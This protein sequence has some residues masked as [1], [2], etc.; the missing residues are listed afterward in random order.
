MVNGT[1]EVFV[2]LSVIYVSDL[3][4]NRTVTVGYNLLYIFIT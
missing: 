3:L 4:Q 2:A 1:S